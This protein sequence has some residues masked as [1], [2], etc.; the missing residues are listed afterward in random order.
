MP[1]EYKDIN[2]VPEKKPKPGIAGVGDN[3]GQRI[4][5][6]TIKTGKIIIMIVEFLVLAIFFSRF[7]LNQDLIKL[8]K[9]IDFSAQVLNVYQKDET[10]LRN[11]QQKIEK[12]KAIDNSKFDWEKQISFIQSKVPE[13]MNIETLSIN[14]TTTEISAKVKDASSFGVFVRELVNDPV[15]TSITFSSSRYNTEEKEYEFSMD[16]TMKGDE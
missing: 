8:K 4:F 10:N 7:K 6:W 9:D 15:I 11:A 16:I 3:L 5:Q 12:I 13:L 2:F 14:K 1:E